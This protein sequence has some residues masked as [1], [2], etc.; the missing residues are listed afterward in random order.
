[1]EIVA[2]RVGGAVPLVAD[3][4]LGAKP[5][6]RYLLL[7]MLARTR[8]STVFA[9]VDQLLAREVALKV[10]HASDDQ[11]I[12]AA[13]AEVRTM[14]RF[15]HANIL[16]V[17]E[18][19]DH[20]G[21][22]YSVLELCDADMKTW[23]VGKRWPDVLD[24]I[25][26]AGTGLAA[27]HEVGLVHGDIKPENVLVRAGV[28]KLGDF[29]LAGSAGRWGRI[30]GTP[31][32]IAP[33]L[34]DGQRGPAGDVFALGC[35]TWACL[36]GTPP[37]GDPPSGADVSAATMV[38]VERAR[39]GA[40]LEPGRGDRQ[41]PPVLLAVLRSALAADPA[42]R[43]ALGVYLEQLAAVR[44]RGWF[45]PRWWSSQLAERCGAAG[46]VRSLGRAPASAPRADHAQSA[47]LDRAEPHSAH[48]GRG[49]GGDRSPRAVRGAG[50]PAR[51]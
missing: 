3:K 2:A 20:D 8:C 49:S 9:A 51:R 5:E 31:G 41:V 19:G 4:L 26:E 24:R 1:M 6:H 15:D 17:L 27:I 22:L 28:A 11:A 36:F 37:F 40:M 32:Y 16:R 42:R 7:G 10:H 29:G 34:A 14:S 44:R 39:D 35:A 46:G 48:G 30:A 23:S 50:R 18:F 38:L 13:L 12:L 21:W 43:P 33:E 25:I 45:Q 47:S